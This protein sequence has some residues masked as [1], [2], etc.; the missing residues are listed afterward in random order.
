M[1]GVFEDCIEFEEVTKCSQMSYVSAM[2]NRTCAGV[3]WT[4]T[5]KHRQCVSPTVLGRGLC[6]QGHFP[7]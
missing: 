4:S 2:I 1:S 7:P 5:K 3:G 6:G